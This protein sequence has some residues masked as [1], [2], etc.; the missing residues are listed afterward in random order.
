MSDGER[1]EKIPLPARLFLCWFYTYNSFLLSPVLACL[2]FA[3]FM[4]CLQGLRLLLLFHS[5]IK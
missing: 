1:G 4:A 3:L 5:T 2:I